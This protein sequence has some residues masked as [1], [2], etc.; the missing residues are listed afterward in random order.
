M[1]RMTGYTWSWPSAWWRWVCFSGVTG[2]VARHSHAVAGPLQVSPEE[3]HDLAPQGVV[4]HPDRVGGVGHLDVNVLDAVRLQGLNQD[5]ALRGRD[6]LVTRVG[7]ED[8]WVGRVYRELGR[9]VARQRAGG[10]VVATEV[11]ELVLGEFG[12]IVAC[13]GEVDGG[14]QLH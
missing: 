2:T 6:E 8:G 13:C 7:D 5:F 11:I 9:R 12:G 3:L 10:V 4:Q 1:T 14:T